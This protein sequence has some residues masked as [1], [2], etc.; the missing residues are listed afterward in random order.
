MSQ[1]KSSPEGTGKKS[2][3]ASGDELPGGNIT[4][5]EW[6]IRRYTDV[7]GVLTGGLKIL[8]WPGELRK[9]WQRWHSAVRSPFDEAWW[10]AYRSM[11]RRSRAPC[12]LQCTA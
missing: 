2:S 4:D 11:C 10:T 3:D 5:I 6:S 1:L 12:F 7:Y 9:P 8:H